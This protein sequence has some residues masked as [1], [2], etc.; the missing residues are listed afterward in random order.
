MC[1]SFESY[2]NLLRLKEYKEVLEDYGYIFNDKGEIVNIY[3]NTEKL[4]R[5]ANN[6]PKAGK[7]SAIY[8][9]RAAE[10][11]L[12]LYL[13]LFY[14]EDE[15]DI[16]DSKGDVKM[17]CGYGYEILNNTY[18]HKLELEKKLASEIEEDIIETLKIMIKN[19]NNIIESVLG[20]NSTSFDN[21]SSNSKSKYDDQISSVLKNIENISKTLISLQETIIALSGSKMIESKRIK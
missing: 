3:T 20:H 21:E 14:K 17:I 1:I 2:R 11:V 6:S 7:E 18:K 16:K 8:L 5:W 12:E 9:I 10:D 4:H 13:E 15:V 19:Y